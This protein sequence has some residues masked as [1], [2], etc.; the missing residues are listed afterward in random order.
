MSNRSI[1]FLTIMLV[2]VSFH[3]LTAQEI[4]H[5]GTY[6]FESLNKNSYLGH[7]GIHPEDQTTVLEYVQ[8]K[9][10]KTLFQSYH[11]DENLNFVE[12]TQ[13]SYNIGQEVTDL[14]AEIKNSFDW[15]SN[16]YQGETY[17]VNRLSIDPGWGGKIIIRQYEYIYAFGWESGQYRPKVQQIDKTELKGAKAEK[18]YLYDWVQNNETGEAF[19]I[20]GVKSPKGSKIKHQHARKFQIVKVKPDLDIE[21]LETIS[22]EYNMAINF[23]RVLTNELPE[24][25]YDL[26]DDIYVADDISK[27]KLAVVFSPIKS[28]IGKKTNSPE[29]DGHTLVLINS[30]GAIEKKINYK[31]PV[32]GWVIEDFILS[33]DGNDIYLYGPAKE[34]E[35]INKL[36]P[37]NS[38]LTG[39]DDIK[40][41]KWKS[42]QLMKISNNEKV[43]IKDTDLKEFKANVV[44]PPS[45][46]RSPEYKGKK[47]TKSAHFVTPDGQIFIAGQNYTTKKVTKNEV[48]VKVIDAYKDLVMFHF[49]DKGQLK[50]QYGVRRDKMNR[51]SKTFPTPQDMYVSED[52]SSLYWIYGEIKGF[53]GG[54]A[55][56]SFAG[57]NI[58]TLSKSKLL[59]YPAVAK[60][61]LA[62]GSIDDFVMMG[63]DEDGKQLYYT[64]PDFSYVLS[65][66]NRSLTFVGENKAGTEIWL[67]RMPL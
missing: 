7:V 15:F 26:G 64:N 47:F 37:V 5:Q 39:R 3:Q 13:E 18:I 57:A 34:N 4:T 19:M 42:F 20:V 60:V 63:Q 32:S 40:D 59:Y 1:L 33:D 8:K 30:D 45:Q 61:D 53:R 29:P 21:Y 35:Y 16:K 24:E 41:I 17:T 55:F 6:Q 51:H 46:K 31:A 50:A 56:A 22:F 12:E 10:G 48:T 58:G 9:P 44:T 28:L 36:M 43:W 23:K 67:G 14:I 62:K 38:P 54:F 11:F 52:G 66:D 27:G 25:T 2:A 49:D 65:P